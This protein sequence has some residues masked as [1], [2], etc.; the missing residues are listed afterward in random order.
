MNEPHRILR[1]VGVAVLSWHVA[2]VISAMVC[3]ARQVSQQDWI[4]KAYV[5][6]ESPPSLSQLLMLPLSLLLLR[7]PGRMSGHHGCLLDPKQVLIPS[8]KGSCIE[9]NVTRGSLVMNACCQLMYCLPRFALGVRPELESLPHDETFWFGTVSRVTSH[10][11]HREA[12]DV[13]W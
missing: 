3:A 13:S 11:C 12:V 10:L 1:T 8:S 5:C 7:W 9:G 6:L 2:S 4:E